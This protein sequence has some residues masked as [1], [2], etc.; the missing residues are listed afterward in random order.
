MKHNIWKFEHCSTNNAKLNALNIIQYTVAH[1]EMLIIGLPM[2]VWNI[3]P[4]GCDTEKFTECK[5][6]YQV[7]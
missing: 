1:K 7:C 5:P 2:V 3:I 6:C 4:Q